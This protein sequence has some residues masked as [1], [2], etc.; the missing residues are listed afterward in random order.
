MCMSGLMASQ[1]N[2]TPVKTGVQRI[3]NYSQRLD[4]GFRGKT[5]GLISRLFA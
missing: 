2:V 1:K 5:E 3:Y 4:S